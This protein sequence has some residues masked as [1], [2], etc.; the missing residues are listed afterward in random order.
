MTDFIEL[1]V[2]S[3][4]FII[5]FSLNKMSCILTVELICIYAVF[6]RADEYGKFRIPV[7]FC[8][9]TF[10]GSCDITVCIKIFTG[11]HIREIN[12][13][14]FKIFE[15]DIPPVIA[16]GCQTVLVKITVSLF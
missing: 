10:C 13:Y 14:T 11:E 15:P 1:H 5:E 9:L 16:V 4:I 2:N 3:L 8:K 12:T 7:I 6:I